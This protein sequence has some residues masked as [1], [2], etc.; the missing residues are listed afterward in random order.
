MTTYFLVNLRGKLS[1]N[2]VRNLVEMQKS[3]FSAMKIEN[4]LKF[5][6]FQPGNL[7]YEEI[8]RK[9]NRI[10]DFEQKKQRENV[11][12]IEK[13]EV[14][15]LGTPN[16]ATMVMNKSLSTPFNVAQRKIQRR[17]QFFM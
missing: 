10:F 9:R 8:C 15:Y 12:R 1:G 7:S 13:I 2:H 14:R 16:D 6:L 5:C 11:G 4:V 3:K 17:G